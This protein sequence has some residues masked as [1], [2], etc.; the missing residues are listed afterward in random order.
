VASRSR[1]GIVPLHSA[2][3]R[4]R[5]KSCVQLWAPHDKKDLEGLERVQRRAVR[6]V[7]GLGHKSYEEQ[8]RNWGCLVW[9]RG[10]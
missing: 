8:L 4:L 6:L 10:G 9:R 1:A 3:V 2:L 5:I 7:K